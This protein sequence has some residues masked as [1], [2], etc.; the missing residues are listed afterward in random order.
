M[1]W[2]DVDALTLSCPQTLRESSRISL[3]LLE[4]R[5][6]GRGNRYP[7]ASNE[8]GVNGCD[9]HLKGSDPHE[10]PTL[11][12]LVGQSIFDVN[13]ASLKSV[14]EV[15]KGPNRTSV[16]AGNVRATSRANQRRRAQSSIQRL[17]SGLKKRHVFPRTKVSQEKI[18]AARQPNPISF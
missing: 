9:S 8:V 2:R 10:G 17:T 1:A 11:E 14:N 5:K 16:R 15:S 6:R 13:Q 12:G 4:G 7:H 18:T 3:F